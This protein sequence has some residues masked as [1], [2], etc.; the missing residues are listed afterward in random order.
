MSVQIFFEGKTEE[1]VIEKVCEVVGCTFASIESGGKGQINR[2]LS[3]TLAPDVGQKTIRASILRDLDTHDHETIESVK[4][5]VEDTLQRMFQTRGIQAGLQLMNLEEYENV[6]AWKSD[7][8]DFRL[9]LHIATYRWSDQFI[10]STIDDYVLALA[11]EPNTALALAQSQGLRVDGHRLIEKVTRELP[12]LLQKNGIPLV[13]AKDY[14][15]LYAA[16]IKAHTSPPV[17]AQKTLHHVDDATVRKTFEPL[18]A[19][20]EFL[21]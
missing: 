8:L 4:Q 3:S 21:L 5:S 7:E 6:C 17:F 15:R 11:L 13:E 18:C 9:A 12:D 20:L 2:K 10:K 16:V 14:V 19:A 1:K